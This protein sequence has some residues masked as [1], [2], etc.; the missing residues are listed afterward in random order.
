MAYKLIERYLIFWAIAGS[1]QYVLRYQM[2]Y[3]RSHAVPKCRERSDYLYYYALLCIS[4]K[5]VLIIRDTV[6]RG[7]RFEV[8][9]CVL[10]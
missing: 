4:M 6:V 1:Y 3:I 2:A 9:V 5:V 8:G 10:S 7:S